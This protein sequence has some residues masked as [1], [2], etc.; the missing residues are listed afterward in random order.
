MCE[1]CKENKDRKDIDYNGEIKVRLNEQM[2]NNLEIDYYHYGTKVGRYIPIAFCPMCG[3]LINKEVL[4]KISKAIATQHKITN[5]IKPN[6]INPIVPD[7]SMLDIQEEI[8]KAVENSIF[9][10]SKLNNNLMK[11]GM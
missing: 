8:R 6:I 11:G 3:K 4:E 9:D 7:T 2:G 10:I 1:Y 5:E